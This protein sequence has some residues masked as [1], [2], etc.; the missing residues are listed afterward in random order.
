MGEKKRLAMEMQEMAGCLRRAGVNFIIAVD[1]GRKGKVH[2]VMVEM[3]SQDHHHTLDILCGI[4]EVW[5]DGS[6]K[7]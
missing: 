7:K 5:W 6:H 3:E 4:L 1:L 2:N